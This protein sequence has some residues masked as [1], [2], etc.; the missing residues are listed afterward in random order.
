MEKTLYRNE[1]DKWIAGVASGL[2]DY[3]QIDVKI[4]RLLFCL[5]IPFLAGTGLLVYI[6]LWIV[7]PVKNDPSA[8]F[9]KFND[10]FQ[11]NQQHSMFNSPNAFSNPSNSGDQTKWNTPNVEDNFKAEPSPD[12]NNFGQ[13]KP[14]DTSKT[15]GGLILLV[16]GLYLFMRYTLDVLPEW[17]SIFKIWKLWPIAIIAIGVSLI[18][19]KQNK[20]EWEKFKKSTAESQKTEPVAPVEEAPIVDEPKDSTTPNS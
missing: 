1:H 18:F 20:S 10:Y 15:I 13:P 7:A 11:Q 2:A 4:V 9:K 16:I 12:P 6:V 19:R 17:F 3:L 8:N 14:N 5:S